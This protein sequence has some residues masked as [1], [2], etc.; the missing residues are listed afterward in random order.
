[1]DETARTEDASN[2]LPTGP[3]LLIWTMSGSRYEATPTG[4]R[5]VDGV[6]P[7][8]RNCQT[9]GMLKSYRAISVPLPGAPWLIDW[10]AGRRT[11]TST[12]TN[13]T[14]H[15]LPEDPY[16]ALDLQPA[17]VSQ[18]FATELYVRYRDWSQMLDPAEAVEPFDSLDEELARSVRWLLPSYLGVLDDRVHGEDVKLW[19]VG[20]V[21]S[22]A[23]CGGP[24]RGCWIHAPRH[25]GLRARPVVMAA[26]RTAHRICRH[27]FLH[28]DPDDL[29]FQPAAHAEHPRL[30][31]DC[32]NCTGGQPVG[33]TG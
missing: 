4:A 16:L 27:G 15:D 11:V 32:R 9:E 33:V 30:E 17:H 3:T 25:S 23:E 5:R 18:E 12:V 14:T 6:R 8:T 31:P 22:V 26:D 10:G 7:P 1:M 2:V 29:H 21:H 24:A 28:C 20:G 13:V 19:R